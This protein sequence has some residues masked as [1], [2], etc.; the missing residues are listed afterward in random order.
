MSNGE[1]YRVALL[2]KN[3]GELFGSVFKVLIVLYLNQF[4]EKCTLRLVL[5]ANLPRKA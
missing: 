3:C 5:A 1:Y 4:F 2:L